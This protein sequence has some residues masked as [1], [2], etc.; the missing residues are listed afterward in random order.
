MESDSSSDEHSHFKFLHVYKNVETVLSQKSLRDVDLHQVIL[1][2]NQS[3]VSLFCNP[4]FA[5]GYSKASKHLHLQSNGGTMT[6]HRVAEIGDG[7]TKV[8]FSK[9]AITNILS[10]KMVHE[11]YHVSYDCEHGQFVIHRS[12]YGRPDMVF[13]MHP[14]GLHIYNPDGNV[15]CFATTVKGNKHHFTK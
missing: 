14:S 9:K 8:W 7:K 15:F 11:L 2:K 3:T 5:S 4:T 13:R 1:L 6:V 12:K 10:L